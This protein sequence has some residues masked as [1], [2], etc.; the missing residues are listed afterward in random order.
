MFIVMQSLFSSGGQITLIDLHM[1]LALESLVS[2]QSV[3]LTGVPIVHNLQP[4]I[5]KL[6]DPSMHMSC[7]QRLLMQQT[8]ITSI[9]CAMTAELKLGPRLNT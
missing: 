6:T 3:A 7:M 2:I 5:L 9:N 8:D 1:F 4:L